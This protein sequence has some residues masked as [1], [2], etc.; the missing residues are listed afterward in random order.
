MTKTLLVAGYWLL[1]VTIGHIK[2]SIS[3]HSAPHNLQ[4]ATSN[5]QPATSTSSARRILSYLAVL[6]YI[7]FLP[8]LSSG[9]TTQPILDLIKANDSILVA[10]HAGRI[11]LAKND[12]VKRIPAST[13]KILT[14]LAAFHFLGE[15]YRFTTEFYTDDKGNLK[16]KGYGDPLLISEVLQEIASLLAKK[17]T[18]CNSLIIDNSYFSKQVTIPGASCSANP[19]DAPLSALSA[20]FNTVNFKRDNSGRIISAE[21]QTPMIPYASEKIAKKIESDR[22]SLFKDSREASLYAGHLV[23]YFLRENGVTVPET[24]RMGTVLP[25]DKLLYTYTSRFAIKD[26]AVKLFQFSNNFI[27]NQVVVALGAN[28]FGP[29]GTLDKGTRAVLDYAQNVL[30]LHG[31][32]FVE[33]SGISRQNRLSARDM[34][35]IL[36]KLEP[37]RSL[38]VK[39]DNIYYKTGTL[40]GIQTRAGYIETESDPLYFVLFLKTPGVNADRLINMIVNAYM[41]PGRH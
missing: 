35:T 29:P 36:K 31:I 12:M 26:V 33:G 17:I 27:A 25:G 1:D 13:L 9:T 4:R 8:S 23:L 40:H 3:K 14:A 7:I 5:Q 30:G 6:L 22:M 20:N 19:Y 2:T 21:P 24:V 32:R 16:V 10:D 39:K 15:D 18:R 37:H 28:V 41:S 11:L 34:L 38:L